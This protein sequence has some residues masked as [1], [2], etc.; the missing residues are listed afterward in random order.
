MANPWYTYAINN[1]H[2]N[3]DGVDLRVPDRTPLYA[4]FAGTV[5]DASYHN[6]GGQAVIIP[7]GE[8]GWA[9]YFIHLN[10]IYV[11][12]GEHV[13][14]ATELGDSGGGIGDLVLHD[15]KVQPAQSQAWYDGHSS[16]YHT[17]YGIFRDE[18]NQLDD[19]NRGWGNKGRQ[20]D[21]T[22][23]I[24]ELRDDQ[25]PS[26]PNSGPGYSPPGHNPPGGPVFPPGTIAFGS[27]LLGQIFGG[28]GITT[29]ANALQRGIVLAV[30]VVF[31]VGGVFIGLHG[32]QAVQMIYEKG[33]EA[34]ADAAKVAAV[35]A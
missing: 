30:G 18:D 12:P 33:K 11:R 32:E 31:V 23:V 4:P 16:G 28:L 6:Y 1:P 26:W 13:D 10:N 34:T 27:G 35:A 14:P 17:E 21:P 5:M 7:D 9:E 8:N 15:G 20:L 24:G 29:P 22:S 2:S 25:A 19:F 3:D